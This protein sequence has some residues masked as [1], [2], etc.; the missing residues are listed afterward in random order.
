MLAGRGG[1]FDLAMKHGSAGEYAEQRVIS[2]DV[3]EVGS[4]E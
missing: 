2:D 1:A 3:P 4:A